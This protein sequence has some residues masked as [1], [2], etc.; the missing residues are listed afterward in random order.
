[1]VA[2]VVKAVWFVRYRAP[3]PVRWLLAN[4]QRL[5]TVAWLV[6]ILIVGN[7]HPASADIIVGPDLAQGAPKTLYETYEYTDYKLTVK[8]DAENSDWFDISETV[9]EVVGFINNLILWASLG[10]IHG[11]LALLEW[12]LNLTLYRDSAAE[13]DTATQ[14]IATEVFWPLISA[15]VAVGVFVTYARWRGE[16]RGFLSD[17]GWVVAA[18]ALAVGFAAGPST[19]MNTVDSVRQDLATGIMTGA[20]RYVDTRGNPTGFPTPEIGGDRQEAATRKLVDGMWSTYGA[21]AWCFGEFHDLNICRVAGS[22][23]LANDE[24]WQQW[25]GVLDD[26]GAPPEFGKYIHWIR[27]QDMTR[28]AYLLV[29]ALLTIPMGL[30]QLRLVISGLIAVTGFL[31]MLVIG[32]MFLTFWPIP[33]W[34]RQLGTRYWV[35]TLGLEL[36]G[37]FITVVIAGE[38]ATSTIIATQAGTYGIGVVAVLNLIVLVA[39]TKA[40]AWMELFTTVGGASPLGYAALLLAVPAARAAARVT[41]GLVRGGARLAGAGVGGMRGGGPASRMPL[42]GFKPGTWRNP[43]APPEQGPGPVRATATRESPPGTDLVLRPPSAM[44]RTRG[45]PAHTPTVV[46]G[47]VVPTARVRPEFPN[48][49][50]RDMRLRRNVSVAQERTERRGRVWLDK[51]GSG[52]SSLDPLSPRERMSGRRITRHS[53]TPQSQLIQQLKDQHKARRK[54]P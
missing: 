53:T 50:F 30:L 23:A 6:G 12:F 4:P 21:T 3:A 33:G 15:T 16:G 22:H 51:K 26:G 25:M 19:V 39:A 45:T 18:G 31:L 36:Q 11:G 9:L 34:F 48:R 44:T 54:Q 49:R 41:S 8:P 17:F 13:I 35:Y 28:T 20:S 42:P 24:Q 37:L 2:A 47:T 38:M 40:T 27:G 46:E 5:L 29:L 43:P 14:M 10:L 32:L 7:A 52:I 1:V